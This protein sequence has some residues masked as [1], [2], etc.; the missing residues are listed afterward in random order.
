LA[1][2][3]RDLADLVER[4]QQVCSTLTL[5]EPGFP[6]LSLAQAVGDL[7]DQANRSSTATKLGTLSVIFLS[8]A[9][10]QSG[11]MLEPVN[12]KFF[13][14]LP[15]SGKGHVQKHVPHVLHR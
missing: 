6:L 1:E 5:I 15:T 4:C 13:P 7:T 14:S 2:A 9:E 12:A 11:G 10:R 3:L 8:R